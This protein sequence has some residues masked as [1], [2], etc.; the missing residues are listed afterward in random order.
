M[1]TTEQQ[2]Q[3]I[4]ESGAA[5]VALCPRL[6]AAGVHLAT[7]D[8][9]G[10]GD[11]G[12][13]QEAG[14]FSA[15]EN[16]NQGPPLSLPDLEQELVDAVEEHLGVRYGSWYDNEG[17]Q[18]RIEI[19]P[20]ENKIELTHGWTVENTITETIVAPDQLEQP[21][22]AL[23]KDMNQAYVEAA[24]LRQRAELMEAK[25]AGTMLLKIA[26]E[27]P[28]GCVTGYSYETESVYDDQGGYFDTVSLVAEFDESKL[29][30]GDPSPEH[31]DELMGT[32]GVAGIVALFGD[33]GENTV[34]S[35]DQLRE[36]INGIRV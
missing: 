12:S 28:E 20:Q 26:D 10:S 16:G 15:G 32:F 29:S 11:E 1:Y 31:D 30:E 7:A 13:V 24:E 21:L 19:R 6:A 33:T 2:Q 5:I 18:G 36:R 4:Q 22:E 3:E 17:G 34:L 14:L 9:W 35:L 23:Q 8:W 25:W 27:Y